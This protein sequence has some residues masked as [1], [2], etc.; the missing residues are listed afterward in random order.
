MNNVVQMAPFYEMEDFVRQ[1]PSEG[2]ISMD[3]ER[4]ERKERTLVIVDTLRKYYAH[5]EYKKFDLNTHKR[6]VDNANTVGKNGYSILYDM[7]AF[8]YEGR[9]HG[10]V[11]YEMSMPTY[12]E[13]GHER[14]RSIPPRGL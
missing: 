5:D 7:R 9:M 4:L 11:E 6:M 3:V 12:Y 13:C 10:L 2:H 8:S 1:I 14:H